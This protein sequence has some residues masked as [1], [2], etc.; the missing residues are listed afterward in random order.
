MVIECHF[1]AT[2]DRPSGF[3]I[4]VARTFPATQGQVILIGIVDV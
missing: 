4:G 2:A 1:E 3:R